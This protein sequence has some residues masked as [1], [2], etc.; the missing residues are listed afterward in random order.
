MLKPPGHGLLQ[1]LASF[2]LI[3]QKCPVRVGKLFGA[4]VGNSVLPGKFDVH[5]DP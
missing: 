5:S 1:D 3:P 4:G 2:S